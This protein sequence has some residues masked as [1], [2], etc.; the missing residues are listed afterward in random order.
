[1]RIRRER[2][3]RFLKDGDRE[4]PTHGGEVIQKDFKRITGFKVIEERL[5]RDARALEHGRTAVNRGIDSDEF[6]LH[7]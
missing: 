1:M 4:F 2:S 7:R 3:A 5:D 6:G